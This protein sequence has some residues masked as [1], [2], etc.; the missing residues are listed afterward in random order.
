[1]E[2]VWVEAV[3]AGLPLDASGAAERERWSGMVPSVVV[4]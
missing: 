1:L 4:A 2:G 3:V